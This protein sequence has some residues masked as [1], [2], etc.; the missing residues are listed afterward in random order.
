MFLETKVDYKVKILELVKVKVIR[1]STMTIPGRI[2]KI[3]ENNLL[4]E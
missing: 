3:P 1:P 4:N 2:C